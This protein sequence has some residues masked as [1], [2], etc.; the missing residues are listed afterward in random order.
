MQRPV[1]GGILHD[2]LRRLVVGDVVVAPLPGPLPIGKRVEQLVA[3]EQRLPQRQQVALAAQ[4]YAELLAHR[5]RAAVAADQ[6]GGADFVGAAIAVL[7]SR[8]NAVGILPQRQELA[9][10]AHGDARHRSPPPT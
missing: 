8:G 2:Q 3:A 9:A 5:A 7:D 4:L 10:E 6:I 1:P